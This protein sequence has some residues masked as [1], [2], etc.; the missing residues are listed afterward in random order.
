[1]KMSHWGEGAEITRMLHVVKC[2][3][4]AVEM[5]SVTTAHIT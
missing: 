4:R 2:R 5:H 1:M 3:Q